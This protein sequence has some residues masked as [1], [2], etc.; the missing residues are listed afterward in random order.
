MTASRVVLISEHFYPEQGATAQLMTDLAN[1]LQKLGFNLKVLTMASPGM[2]QPVTA[3]NV[4]YMSGSG[5]IHTQKNNLLYKGLKGITFFIKALKWC[6][7]NIKKSDTIILVSNPPFIGLVGAILSIIRPTRYIFIFQDIF[8]RSAILSGILKENSLQALALMRLMKLSCDCSHH[9][10]VLS[11]SMKDRLYKDITKRASVHVISNWAIEK[12][13]GSHRSSN[14]FAKMHSYNQYFTVQ[15]SGNFGRLHDIETLL[16][17]S[18]QLRESPIRFVFVGGGYQ[19]KVIKNFILSNNTNNVQCLPYQDRELLPQ[20][21]S[22]CDLAVISLKSGA[23]DTVAPSKFYGIIA[24]GRGVLLI[25]DSNC[26]IAQLV[27]NYDCGVV[28]KP[29]DSHSLSM[30]IHSLSMQPNVVSRMGQNA[31]NLYKIRFGKDKSIRDYAFL[32]RG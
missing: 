8:P 27:I 19:E 32:I 22:A 16:A 12:G 30:K 17:A 21:L 13:D 10:V 6:F 1:G 4:N 14:A 3:I 18:L 23:G 28:I 2:K 20:S 11:N 5:I 7:F 25:C 26:E 31:L 24:S 15:Y 29:G 9:T